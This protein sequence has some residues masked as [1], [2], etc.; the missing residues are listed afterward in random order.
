MRISLKHMS[1]GE[2]EY[3]IIY[4]AIAIFALVLARVIPV[5]DILPPCP[6]KAVTGIPCPTC[7]TARSLV[8]LAHGDI[9]GALILNPLFSLAMMTAL[10]IF[11]ARSARL[12]FNRPRIALTFTNREDTLLRVGIAGVFFVNWIYLIFCL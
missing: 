7:G 5:L 3:G 10:I 12:S 6:F 4:G 9:A 8:H 2:I 11:F 1:P